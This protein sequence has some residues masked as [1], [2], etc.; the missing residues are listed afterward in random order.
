MFVLQP[1]PWG[2]GI[3][4]GLIQ[5]SIRTQRSLLTVMSIRGLLVERAQYGS[6][7]TANRFVITRGE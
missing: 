4:G 2:V 6:T 1:S 3:G 7:L 5:A